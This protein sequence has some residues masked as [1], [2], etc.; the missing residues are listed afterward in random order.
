MFRLGKKHHR[1]LLSTTCRIEFSSYCNNMG[2]FNGSFFSIWE[3]KQI[4]IRIASS[5]NS[6]LRLHTYET[7]VKFL[8]GGP[9]FQLLRQGIGMYRFV[10]KSRRTRLD[11][12][13]IS[14]NWTDSN[15]LLSFE[16]W[17]NNYY[18]FL[19]KWLKCHSAT[20]NSITIS[21]KSSE[22]IEIQSAKQ[23]KTI[24]FFLFEKNSQ[25]FTIM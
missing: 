7:Q 3:W 11:S 15:V 25:S 14:K 24:H 1:V 4:E 21:L 19:H 12:G 18:F 20:Q 2:M 16:S 9:S 8:S 23:C 22:I 13:I 5:A 10:E 17:T 6:I